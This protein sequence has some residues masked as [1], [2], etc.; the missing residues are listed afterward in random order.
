MKSTKRTNKPS[1]DV[2]LD[3]SCAVAR[4]DTWLGA[5]GVALVRKLW[6][7][8]EVVFI[9]PGPEVFEARSAMEVSPASLH[10]CL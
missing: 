4:V 9:S 10:R 5:V 7:A 6:S 2:G 1:Q 8:L 3:A